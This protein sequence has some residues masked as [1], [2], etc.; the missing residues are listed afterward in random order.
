MIEGEDIGAIAQSTLRVFPAR[1]GRRRR[2]LVSAYHF[3]PVRGSEEG[4]GWNICSRLAAYHDVSVLTRSWSEKLWP[5]DEQHFEDAER[6]MRNNGPVRGL[7]VHFVRSPPLSRLLQTY[8]HVSLRSPLYF[9]GYAAWQRA[10]YRKAVR[11]HHERPFDVTHQLT[12]TSF[13]EPGY[14]WK[15][16]APFIWGPTGGGGNI[17]WSY[18][19]DFSNHDRLYYAL[20]NIANRI[21]VWTKWR[22]RR[23]SRLA[24]RVLVN[25]ADLKTMMGRWGATPHVMLDMGAPNWRGQVRCFDGKRPLRLCWIGLHIGRKGLSLILHVLAELKQRGLAERVHLTIIGSGPETEVWQALCRQL[26]VQEMTTWLGQVPFLQMRHTFES[27]DAL[28]MSSLQEGTPSV[29]MEALAIGLPVL[30]HDVAGMSFAIDE[31][32]GVKIPFRDR[33][34]SIAGFADAAF[35][36]ATSQGLLSG[37]SE[38]ALRRSKALSW[39]AKVQEIS[40][41]YDALGVKLDRPAY[42]RQSFF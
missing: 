17:P 29:V 24:K 39:D 15:L 5:Q 20:K 21:H 30:C 7:T 13:R 35:R 31:S 14:L 23:A 41:F 6:F 10:A 26:G 42:S 3:S 9:Q 1:D 4:I 18:F 27:Q 34:T 19:A 16:D 37:L 25:S 28:V 36:L 12:T 22:S 2:V 32:C 8:P 38:G 33:Q 40:N 11:L